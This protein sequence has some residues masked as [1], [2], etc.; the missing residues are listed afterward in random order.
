MISA[1]F[2]SPSI[3]H[4]FVFHDLINDAKLLL[5]ENLV[6]CLENLALRAKLT[7]R[8]FGEPWFATPERVPPRMIVFQMNSKTRPRFS[9]IPAG[10]TTVPHSNF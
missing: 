6:I 4:Y 5:E 3:N 9:T 1:N 7:I 2:T 8:T 10:R